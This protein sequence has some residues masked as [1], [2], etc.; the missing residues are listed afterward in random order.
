MLLGR[1]ARFLNGLEGIF[2]A[3][4]DSLALIRDA[5][6]G[7]FHAFSLSKRLSDLLNAIGFRQILRARRTRWAELIWFMESSTSFGSE[8]RVMSVLTNVKP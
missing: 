1:H 7:L 5:L 8:M 2:N 6:A 4:R 3:L